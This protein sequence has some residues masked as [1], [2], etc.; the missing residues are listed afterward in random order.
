MGIKFIG[1]YFIFRCI[2]KS[3]CARCLVPSSDTQVG[4]TWVTRVTLLLEALFF[5]AGVTSSHTLSLL[6]HGNVTLLSTALCKLLWGLELSLHCAALNCSLKSLS[7][8]NFFIKL[9]YV[10]YLIVMILEIDQYVSILKTQTEIWNNLSRPVYSV[11]TVTKHVTKTT[12]G[13][14]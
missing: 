4:S 11:T 8:I 2:P 9:A 3:S 14:V 10:I 6:P 7:L 5:L 13:R 1:I 12:Q